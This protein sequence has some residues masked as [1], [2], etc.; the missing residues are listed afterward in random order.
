MPKVELTDRFCQAAKPTT[1][2]Q[3]D[4]FDAIVKGLCLTASSGG[5]RT[6]YLHY[7]RLSDGKRQRMKLGT[8]PDIKLAAAREKAR[9]V[10]G[11]IINGADPIAEKKAEAAS[12]SVADLVEN[13]VTR[14]ASKNR[15]GDEVA[16][17]LRKNVSGQD[18]EGHTIEGASTGVIGNVKLSGLHRRDLT[19][20]IDAITDRGATTEAVR[21]F[22]DLRAMV[23]WARG[24]GDLD[25]NLMEGMQP[26]AKLV[27]RDR[28]LTADEIHVMWKALASAD[29]WE[30]SRRII[31]L[32]L[33][34]GA[35][36]GEVCGMTRDEIDL[37]RAL[38]VLPPERVKNA[39]R[40]TLPLPSM[41]V[42]MIR[43][44]LADA[45]K[46]AKRMERQPSEFIFPG[47]GGK[48]PVGG[49]AIAKA[50][51]RQEVITTGRTTILSVEP[52]TC[53]DLRRTCA[54]H[55]AELGVNPFIIGHILNHITSIKGTITTA[56]YARYDY[57][58]EKTEALNIW[59]D[60]LAGILFDGAVANVV[61][62]A[63][64][65]A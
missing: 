41:A 36:V 47:V 14:R 50:L 34:L 10:R 25:A 33:I 9:E 51:K 61:P 37:D 64:R 53:H 16:R 65:A 27:A 28:V 43:E 1:G 40:H 54:T 13:Y 11:G 2:R 3:T 29:M 49:A 62:I 48:G 56:V 59:A 4:Y 63:E 22:E 31:R 46:L 42:D 24:R 26:P 45:D 35:R 38:W 58:K 8:F 52:F 18:A 60:R 23:R 44:Q 30:G 55:L 7:T 17:R 5:T 19:K 6:F 57:L 15:S 39:N 20:A 21:V 12:M 32:C